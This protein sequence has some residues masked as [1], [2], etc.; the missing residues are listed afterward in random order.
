MREGRGR[1]GPP[2]APVVVTELLR[3]FDAL[4]AEAQLL[5]PWKKS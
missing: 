3:G 4:W 2:V 1:G 5:C